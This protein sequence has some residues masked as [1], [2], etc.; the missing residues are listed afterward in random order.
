[1]PEAGHRFLSGRNISGREFFAQLP[2]QFG[3]QLGTFIRQAQQFL[4]PVDDPGSSQYELPVLQLLEHAAERLFGDRQQFQQFAD[5]QARLAR[6]EI[7][8]A[9]M[10]PAKSLFCQFLIDRIGQSCV[11][12]IEQFDAATNLVLAQK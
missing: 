3:F 4:P 8:G 1:M 2:E 11:A 10:R 7:Q 12:E 5:G 9:V 6:Y